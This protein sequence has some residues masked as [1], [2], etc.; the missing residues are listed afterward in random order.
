MGKF[1]I[2]LFDVGLYLDIWYVNLKWDYCFIDSDVWYVRTLTCPK[3][4]KH[5][6]KYKCIVGV[7][8]VFHKYKVD[9]G[10]VHQ[11]K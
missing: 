3:K 5:G 11:S 6:Y 2:L 1:D 10:H 9:V 7:Y 8:K 4:M